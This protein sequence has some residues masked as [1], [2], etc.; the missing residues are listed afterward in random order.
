MVISP[1]IAP[2]SIRLAELLKQEMQK[3]GARQFVGMQRRLDIGARRRSTCPLEPEHR[4]PPFDTRRIAGD[5]DLGNVHF[6]SS[7]NSENRL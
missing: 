6:V 5:D 3:R 4:Q 1:R 7:S 2:S